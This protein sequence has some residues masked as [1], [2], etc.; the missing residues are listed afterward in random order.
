MGHTYGHVK[1]LVEGMK[2][3]LIPMY[4][5]EPF[6]LV[7][8]YPS[9]SRFPRGFLWDEGFHLLLICQWSN[10]ICIEVFRT[11]FDTISEIADG[12]IMHE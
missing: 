4:S 10:S 9:R 3:K 2:Q 7:A 11:W 1:H 5:R 6:E 12:E 8:S